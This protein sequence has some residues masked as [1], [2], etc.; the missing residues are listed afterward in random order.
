MDGGCDAGTVDYDE[1]FSMSADVSK[2]ARKCWG[3]GGEG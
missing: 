2:C 1:C 3:K